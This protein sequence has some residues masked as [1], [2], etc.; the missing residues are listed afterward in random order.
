MT[1]VTPIDSALEAGD[2]DQR[3]VNGYTA[4]HRAV[5]DGN[6]A[7]V[8]LL[9][10]H[11]ADPSVRSSRGECETPVEMAERAGLIVIADLLRAPAR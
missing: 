2:L 6:V 4:L 5:A 11:G 9:L 10:A 7:A 8:R 3:D 1:R